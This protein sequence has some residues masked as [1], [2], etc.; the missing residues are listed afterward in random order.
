VGEKY[1]TFGD[2][3]WAPAEGFRPLTAEE[4]DPIRLVEEGHYVT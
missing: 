2:F 1:G 3:F 4:M